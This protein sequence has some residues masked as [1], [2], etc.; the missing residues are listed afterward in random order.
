MKGPASILTTI[1]LLLNVW[2][3]MAAFPD[4]PAQN[5]ALQILSRA[6]MSSGVCG[7]LAVRANGDTL[8][9][10]NSNMALVPASNVKILSTGIALKELGP[11]YRYETAISY[12]GF[13]R[14]SVLHGDLYIV[15]GCD[16]TT[17]SSSPI[18]DKVESLFSAWKNMI[19]K[20]GIRSIEGYVI[21]D[22]R[23]IKGDFPRNETWQFEDMG[24]AYGS[25]PSGLNF[26]ENMQVFYIVPGPVEGSPATVF[27]KY[28]DTPWMVY[29]HSL[30]T[31]APYSP[32]RIVY[33]NTSLGPYGAVR[34]YFPIDLKAYSFE[35]S[36]NFG[37]YTCSYYFYRFLENA[38]IRVGKGFAD[39]SPG[40]H[41]RSS[42]VNPESGPMASASLTRIGSTFSPSLLSIAEETN[43]RSNNFF[44]ETLFRT[45]AI[46][47]HGDASDECCRRSAAESFLKMGLNTS[48][49][50]IYDGC[51]LSRINYVSA[52]FFVSFLKAMYSSDVAEV[53]F[54]T[55]PVAGEKKT[56]VEARLRRYPE[57]LRFRV[58]MKSGSMEGIHCFS[59]YIDSPDSDPE[60]SVFFSVLT[61]N[62]PGHKYLVYSMIDDIIAA[63]A[64][65]N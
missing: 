39:V 22:S 7:L 3:A 16:P 50:R 49:C 2:S 44:A 51:G 35:A 61:D 36:N 28:P 55:L 59:G 14:D 53:F 10:I 4:T 40:G 63:I 38:G 65:D 15:G 19:Q 60:H 29:H 57:S 12:S 21:G 25:Y 48:G 1:A 45:V 41:I 6:P 17:G 27:P 24:S 43:H 32:N 34:G 26:Y 37:A 52:S 5:K 56:T 23:R 30:S 9:C 31:S 46:N 13:V 47:A 11:D 42:L 54:S 62:I 33:E 58:H 18:A 20:A 8:A 64:G